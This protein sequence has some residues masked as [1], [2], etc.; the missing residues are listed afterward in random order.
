MPHNRGFFVVTRHFFACYSEGNA[1]KNNA[2]TAEKNRYV[3]LIFYEER[4]IKKADPSFGSAFYY[5]ILFTKYD[6]PVQMRAIAP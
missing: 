6:A 4:V 2:V 1:R 5:P 3:V